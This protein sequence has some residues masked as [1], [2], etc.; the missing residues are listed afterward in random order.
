M[1]CALFL[2]SIQF[3][4]HVVLLFVFHSKL[5]AILYQRKKMR[6]GKAHMHAKNA[7]HFSIS[8][9][10]RFQYV[11]KYFFIFFFANCIAIIAN[12]KISISNRIGDNTNETKQR[13][14]KTYARDRNAFEHPPI[15]HS[16][17]YYIKFILAIARNATTNVS[18]N[19]CTL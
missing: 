1:H 14:K 4:I 13:S 11:R 3:S 17:M 10:Y 7:R 16:S 2:H 5:S 19:V 9:C 6:L 8:F 15:H 18:N 12:G